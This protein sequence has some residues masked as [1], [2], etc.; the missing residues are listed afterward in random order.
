LALMQGTLGDQTFIPYICDVSQKDQ[1][2][3]VS[4]QL[5]DK[6]IIPSLFFLNAGIAGEAACE[7]PSDFKLNKHEEIFATNYFGVLSWVEEWLS[8]GL[9][10][11]GTIFVVTS[12]INAIFAP[13]TGSAYAASK[14]AIAKAFEGFSLTYY[15][16]KVVFSVVY[17]GPVATAG[18]KGNLPFT[19]KPEKMAKYMINKAL[20]RKTHSENSVFYAFLSRI[21]RLL[22]NKLTMKILGKL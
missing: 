16:S 2:H 21:L 17:A 9:Q 5:Q 1:V 19:W 22:P 14:A 20:N 8:I 3:T 4:K 11:E 18:L 10:S 12:S 6:N 13:P 7:L 15:N